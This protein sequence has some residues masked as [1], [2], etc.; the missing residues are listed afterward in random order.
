MTNTYIFKNIK[1][2]FLGGLLA[3]S[4]V[5]LLLIVPFLF[6]SHAFATSA[7]ASKTTTIEFQYCKNNACKDIENARFEKRFIVGEKIPMRIVIKN[8]ENAPVFSVQ[9]WVKFNSAVVS[10]SG[11]NDDESAFDLAAPGEFKAVNSKGEIRIGRATTGSAITDSEIIVADFLLEIKKN[12]NLGTLQFI[13]F[14]KDAIGKTAVVTIQGNIPANIIETQPKNL[15]FKNLKS[16]PDTGSSHNNTNADS[17]VVIT[18]NTNSNNNNNNTV[19]VDNISVSNSVEGNAETVTSLPQPTGFRTRTFEDGKV[20]MIWELSQDAAV[21]GYYLYYSTTSGVYM[22]RRDMGKTNMYEF[23][24]NFFKKDR[25]VF[26]AVQAYAENGVVSDFSDETFVITG[27]PGTSSH[28]FF[29]QIFPDAEKVGEDIAKN[30]AYYAKKGASADISQNSVQQKSVITG[31]RNI[32]SGLNINIILIM[33]GAFLF[34]AS[35]AYM[36]FRKE[37]V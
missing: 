8:P 1:N 7:N 15:V 13:D 9:S 28:P 29:E 23:D 35:G 26:F 32:Q 16:S 34:M 10:V 4:T 5:I 19:I 2:V 22:H 21:K 25:K 30:K 12:P 18:N 3:L 14:K 24:K 11:L 20:Q 36:I 17:L 27:N 31:N 37:E 33:M 6:R